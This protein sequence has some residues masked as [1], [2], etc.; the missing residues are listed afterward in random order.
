MSHGTPVG[1]LNT[2][3]VLYVYQALLHY[4]FS[5]YLLRANVE[6]GIMMPI[7]RPTLP[8]ALDKAE[9]SPMCHSFPH[10]HSCT[11]NVY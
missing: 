7:F 4:P 5:Q 9:G 3:T 2:C 11:A 8:Q 6:K 1:I 10:C